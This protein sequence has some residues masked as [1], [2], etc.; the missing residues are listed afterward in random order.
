MLESVVLLNILS[1]LLALFSP[2]Y[3]FSNF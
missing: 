1:S 2:W 3:K